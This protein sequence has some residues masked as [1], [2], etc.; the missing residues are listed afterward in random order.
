LCQKSLVF[1]SLSELFLVHLI[2][3]LETIWETSMDYH[4]FNDKKHFEP[5][6]MGHPISYLHKKLQSP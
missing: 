1:S 3:F 2:S 6:R 4:M 5:W